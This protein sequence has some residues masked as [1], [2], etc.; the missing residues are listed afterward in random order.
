MGK[1]CAKKAAGGS[2]SLQKKLRKMQKVVFEV[3]GEAIDG[4]TARKRILDEKKEKEGSAPGRLAYS[5]VIRTKFID[6]IILAVTRSYPPPPDVS[7]I[8]DWLED[9]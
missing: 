4:F 6:T 1:S 9:T 3:E 8:T 5:I 2:E 7:V